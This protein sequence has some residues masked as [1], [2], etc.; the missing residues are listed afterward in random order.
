MWCWVA[1]LD[2]T[3][4]VTHDGDGVGVRSI[5]LRSLASC[6]LGAGLVIQACGPN[7]TLSSADAASDGPRDGGSLFHL[8]CAFGPD[9]LDDAEV[10]ARVPHTCVNV[11]LSDFD[12][13][14]ATSGDCVSVE[15]G[16]LCPGDNDC[17][18][19]F[20]NRRDY[21]KYLAVAGM[22]PF[23]TGSCPGGPGINPQCC[24]GT[25]T[26]FGSCIDDG[27]TPAAD[28]RAEASGATDAR[29]A[30]VEAKTPAETGE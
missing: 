26:N 16:E 3:R 28:G 14:C 10:P 8:E 11:R 22:I 6:L 24:H 20:I 9:Y 19:G 2:S 27:G 13:S 1:R 18:N 30:R 12:T 23:C 4:A 7:A 15:V 25:C 5:S 21:S 17:G 29:D